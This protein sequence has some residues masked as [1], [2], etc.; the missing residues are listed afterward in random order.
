MAIVALAKA[1]GRTVSSGRCCPKSNGE[2][3][4]E[5]EIIVEKQREGNTGPLHVY[6]DEKALIFRERFAGKQS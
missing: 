3:T 4:G 1:R 2:W 5:D 6:Y